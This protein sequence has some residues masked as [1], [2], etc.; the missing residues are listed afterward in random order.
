MVKNYP[1]A[2]CEILEI[3]K[4]ISPEELEKIPESEINFLRENKDKVYEFEYN[5]EKSLN[6]QEISRETKSIIV[7]LFKN[8]FAS[9]KQLEKLD[10]ILEENEE[11]YQE[12]L[13]KKYNPDDL[14]KNNKQNSIE[15]TKIENKDENRD[16]SQEEQ[17]ALIPEENNRWYKKIVN[18][19]RKIL[20]RDKK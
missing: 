5:P 7:W 10:K 15:E 6:N 2:Y 19:F 12:E 17:V 4:Y 20:K 11:R 14:F 9:E 3:L 18:F 16:E 13:R 8:Y 1:K